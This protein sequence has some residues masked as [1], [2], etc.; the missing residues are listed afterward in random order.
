SGKAKH[1][2]HM[3]SCLADVPR[4][5]LS[6]AQGPIPC[7]YGPHTAHVTLKRPSWER[8]AYGRVT[9]TAHKR[10]LCPIQAKTP[11]RTAP[12]PVLH[13]LWLTHGHRGPH[14]VPSERVLW[15][16][17]RGSSQWRPHALP[18]TSAEGQKRPSF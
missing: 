14:S 16:G 17:R 13:D 1:P 7:D 9:I 8:P 11:A 4:S 5:P 18:A 2:C 10:A 6:T 15:S 12:R 3:C